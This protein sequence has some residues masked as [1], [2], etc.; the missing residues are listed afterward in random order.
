MG[1]E[2]IV[3]EEAA[4]IPA[5][6]YFNIILPLLSI[7][8]S[9]FLCISTPSTEPYNHFSQ[10][11]NSGSVT[12][13][14][15]SLACEA[16]RAAGVADAC[17]HR[18][19]EIPAWSSEEAR[20]WVKSIYGDRNKVQFMRESM[21]VNIQAGPEVY[22]ADRI[23]EFFAQPRVKLPD[24][25]IQHVFVAIDPAGGSV[26]GDAR[27]SDYTVLSVAEPR[28]AAMFLIGLEAI[29]VTPMGLDFHAQIVEHFNRLLKLDQLRRAVFVVAIENNFGVEHAT[30]G[31]R[32]QRAFPQRIILL[33]E[34]GQERDKA[35]VRTTNAL[36]RDAVA[37]TKATLLAR[38]MV[39]AEEL[40]SLHD[41]PR[42]MFAE[43]EQQLLRYRGFLDEAKTPHGHD[44]LTYSGKV[45]GARDDM[46]M[47]LMLALWWMQVFWSKRERYG[48]FY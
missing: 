30:L 33:H 41:K 40:V 21:G 13:L 10:M 42:E 48:Q 35:G 45:D 43:F 25:A 22:P 12:K 46:A 37:L 39:V 27:P 9:S 19:D 17:K 34:E 6:T 5:A 4:F 14:E 32:L 16:C 29:D 44:K 23:H 1:G 28:G 18:A 8:K 36:K 47:A 24:Q 20:E 26:K 38:R 3:C 11:L 2:L 31:L 7:A 15:V